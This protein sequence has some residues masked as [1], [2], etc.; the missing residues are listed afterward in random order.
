MQTKTKINVAGI[1]GVGGYFGGLLAKHYADNK[2]VAINFLARGQHLIEIQK[3]GLKIIQGK[4]EII[5]KPNL[6]TDNPSEIGIADLIM[7]CTK[8]Y[9]IETIAHQLR[10]CIGHNTVILPLLNGVD[11][12]Q[13]LQTIYPENIVLDG[14]VYI[15]SRLK[16]AGAIENSGN[17]QTLY[18]GLDNFVN[19]KLLLFE[20]IFKQ[21]GIE[22][23]LALK[24]ST[25]I[26]EKYIFL[27]PTAT[28]T[29]F[30]DKCIGEILTD[31]ECLNTIKLLI[32]EVS[33]V[34]KAKGIF[35][36]E[37]IVEKTLLKLNSLPYETTSSMH[38]DYK[39]KKAKTELQT[40]TGYVLTEGAKHNV[41]TP[42]FS[43]LM[44]ALD[45]K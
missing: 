41:S 40:L 15:V 39:N 9:D 19:E 7:I 25:I 30:Y 23:K 24:I 1:G 3:N 17:I 44:A 32:D 38:S 35:I 13:I 45:K 42:T 26:W 8:S 36:S 43:K 22:A 28:A 6:A 4:H 37:D 31:V 20:T 11:N 27:S 2:H 33:K 16:E 14:C 5:A 10:P 12:K 29:C 34:A 21:A 18:F